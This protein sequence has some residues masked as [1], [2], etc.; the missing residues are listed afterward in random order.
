VVLYRASGLERSEFCRSHGTA[1]STLNWHLKKQ[2]KRQNAAEGNALEPRRLVAVEVAATVAS[3]I[4]VEPAVTLTVLLSI[5]RRVEV[6]RG[7]D[8]ETLAQLV[9]VLE[10]LQSVFGLGGQRASI[11]RWERPT[12]AKDLRAL[13]PGARP[14]IVRPAER[15]CV[16]IFQRAA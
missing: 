12:R 15:A 10:R 4:G 14:F 3:G 5:S 16:L 8:A 9:T 1:L 6:G 7:F 2:Q 11:L 13:W